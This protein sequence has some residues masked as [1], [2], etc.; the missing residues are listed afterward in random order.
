MNG[1]WRAAMRRPAAIVA[2]TIGL[3]ALMA[4]RQAPPPKEYELTGQIL[5]VKPE[6]SEVVVRHDDIKGFMPAMTMPY[7]V[8]DPALLMG[9]KPGDLFKA[10]LVVGE[11]DAYLSSLNVTGHQPLDSAAPVA[12][13]PRILSPGEPVADALLVDQGAKPRPLSSLRGHRVALTFV[14]T[15]CP[16]PDYCPLMERQ[17]VEV[18]QRIKA[19]PKLADVRLVTLTL[20]PEFDTPAVLRPHALDVGA[21]PAVWSYVTGEP[22]EVRRFAEQFGVHYEI[23]QTNKWQ[24]IHNLRTAVI[25]PEGK[26]V[27]IES[28]NFWKPADLVADLEKT[29][30]P[31]R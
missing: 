29:P 17:F 14:Y 26:V 15:R 28:G 30:A 7:K 2:A 4:C 9:R 6:R 23:D 8:Q 25:D 11:V 20:D 27:K 12:D 16:L 19:N 18:Q 1:S 24:L 13:Q 31:A 21:D 3:V 22:N 10:T 5:S